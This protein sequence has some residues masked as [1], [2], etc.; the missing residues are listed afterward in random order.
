LCQLGWRADQ[1]ETTPCVASQAVGLHQKCQRRGV[2]LQQ[3]LG[4]HTQRAAARGH[5]QLQGLQQLWGVGQGGG[6][7]ELHAW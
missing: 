6:V 3:G 2:E 1:L 5:R 7:G 4:V